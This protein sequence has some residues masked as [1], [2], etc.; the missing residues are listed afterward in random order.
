M[1]LGIKTKKELFFRHFLVGAGAFLLVYLFWLSKDSVSG[2]ARLWRSLGNTG[3]TLLFITLAIGPLAKLSGWAKR[4]IA[5][6]R[7]TGIWFALITVFHFLLVFNYSLTEPRIQL[8]VFLG[9]IGLTWAIILA[10][11]SSDRAVNW[12]GISSWKWLHNMAYVI[13][14]VASAHA[15]Y[16]LFWHYPNSGVF[17]YLFIAMFVSI[18]ALQGLAFIKEVKRLKSSNVKIGSRRY[19]LPISRQKTVAKGTGEVSFDNSQAKMN[20][21]A[22]QHIKVRIPEMLYDDPKGNYRTFSIC[23]SP[24]NKKELCVAFRQSGSGFKKTLMKLPIGTMIEIEGP[25]GRFT[26]PQETKEPLILV[27]GGIGITP[28]RSMIKFS[29]EKLTK[30]IITLLYGNRDKESSAYLDELTETAEKNKR[31]SLA[32]KFGVIDE[33]FLRKHKDDKAKWYIVGPPAMVH[34]TKNI[35]AK[36][37]VDSDKIYAEEFDGY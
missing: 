9:Y 4:I 29:H 32:N 28:L 2:D 25:L 20:F 7:E 36:L 8:P 19:L 23:S 16:F 35:L 15:A 1:L 17:N 33:E 11:T 5:W 24:N 21:V 14:Y 18:I 27:A 6:R 13:F 37:K 31:I 26:L 12:L 10:L 34:A 30:H 22:G 3:Y